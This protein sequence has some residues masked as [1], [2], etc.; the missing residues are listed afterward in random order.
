MAVLDIIVE[1]LPIFSLFRLHFFYVLMLGH[2]FHLNLRCFAINSFKFCCCL[3]CCYLCCAAVAMCGCCAV[4]FI[5]LLFL[6][7]KQN[8]NNLRSLQLTKVIRFKTI[9]VF[10]VLW[11]A[12][13]WREIYTMY[14]V[15]YVCLMSIYYLHHLFLS[16]DWLWHWLAFRLL[17]MY[18]LPFCA[19]SV[20]CPSI[21]H[22]FTRK[23]N[24]KN[25]NEILT[26]RLVYW[27]VAA[28]TQKPTPNSIMWL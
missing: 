25:T 10:R 21:T 26:L 11:C 19:F 12:A 17:T 9:D 8:A 6:S 7:T 15:Q 27:F 18:I 4:Y 3:N 14:S 2:S 24:G 22:T 5:S 20:W 1:C 28:P 16:L 13:E 23:F